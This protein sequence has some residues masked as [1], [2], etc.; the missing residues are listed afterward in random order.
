MKNKK[1][2]NLEQHKQE[3]DKIATNAVMQWSEDQAVSSFFK[4]QLGEEYEKE[5][6]S[7]A[8]KLFKASVNKA[9]TEEKPEWTALIFNSAAKGEEKTAS[10]NVQVNIGSFLDELKD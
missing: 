1:A 8:E 9:I 10:T 2:K 4:K 5:G 7:T 6:I 3:I